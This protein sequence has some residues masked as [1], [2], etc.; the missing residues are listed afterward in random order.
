VKLIVVSLLALIL[1]V[2]GGMYLSQETGQVVLMF[3]DYAIQASLGFLILVVIVGF[4]LFYIFTRIVFSLIDLPEKYRRWKKTRRHSKSEYYLTQGFMATTAGDWNSAEKFFRKGA[5]YSRLPIVNYLAAARAAQQRG[6]TEQRDYYLRLAYA[7]ESDSYFSVGVTRAE[8]QLDQR[9]TEEA[10]ATLKHLDAEAPGKPQVKLM[11]LEASS[12]LKDWQH[13]LTL[14]NELE[15]LGVMP[16]EKIRGRQLQAYAQLLNAAAGDSLADLNQAWEKIPKRLKR[17]LYLLEVYV[18][19]RLGFADTS[20]CEPMLRQ[21]IKHQHDAALIRLYGLVDG[22][23]PAKQLTFIEKLLEK[24]TGDFILLLTAGRLYKRAQLWGKAKYSLEESL[25][26][27]PLP[28]TCYE[29][30][31]LYEYRGDKDRANEYFQKGLALVA[32]PPLAG[33]TIGRK[34]G[35]DKG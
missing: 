11:L 6:A 25:K 32:T 22:S 23:D 15:Q 27:E 7:E 17:E 1:V 30:A 18:N 10:Y 20:D 9:Q 13:S 14:L 33:I 21:V 28:E 5:P 35:S 29:I 4:I 3:S 26:I 12:E 2:A 24:N 34:L 8:L 19:G 16:V 31:T